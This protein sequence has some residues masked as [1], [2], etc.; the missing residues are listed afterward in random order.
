MVRVLMDE[1]HVQT[2]L[3][4]GTTVSLIKSIRDSNYRCALLKHAAVQAQIDG[5]A[6]SIGHPVTAPS[7]MDEV[8]SHLGNSPQYKCLGEYRVQPLVGKAIAKEDHGVS[9]MQIEVLR[10]TRRSGGE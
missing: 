4:G 3:A 5:T 8:E 6:C 2:G 7:R 1:F 10:P 9:V